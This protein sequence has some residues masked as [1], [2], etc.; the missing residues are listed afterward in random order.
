[1]LKIIKN[2]Y[3]YSKMCGAS[4]VNFEHIS[5]IIELLLQQNLNKLMPVGPEKL[6]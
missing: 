6:V 5:H 2:I 1:M 4:I 3:I